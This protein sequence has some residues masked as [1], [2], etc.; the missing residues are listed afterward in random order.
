MKAKQAKNGLN[1]VY[2][3]NCI[4]TV[5]R[6]V[7]E[8]VDMVIT[9][10]PYDDMRQYGG[11]AFKEFEEIADGLFRVLKKGGVVV[12]VV[13]DQTKNGDE[14][15]TSFKQALHFK[16]IGFNLFDTMIYLKPP[17]G[18]V[19]NNKTYWQAFMGSGTV[20]K[21]C[22]LNERNYI[23]SEIN[24]EYCELIQKRLNG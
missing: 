24:K 22:L 3:E 16:T 1:V 12:W 21:M 5:R 14:S 13:G 7:S 2:H 8:S 20:A 4:D 10:P 9:S 11:N 6:M 23:G 19:G 17:R 18:A 15:G